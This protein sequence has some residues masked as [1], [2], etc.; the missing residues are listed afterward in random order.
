M[1]FFIKSIDFLKKNNY[2]EF[3]DEGSLFFLRI[4]EYKVLNDIS[5]VE[6]VYDQIKNIIM[7]KRKVELAKKP[8]EDVYERAK[9]NNEFEIY[10]D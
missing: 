3:S 5:P 1:I 2:T 8:E 9:S 6:I 4:N 7:N 10:N